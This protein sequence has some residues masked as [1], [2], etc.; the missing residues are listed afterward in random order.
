MASRYTTEIGTPVT[1]DLK[2]LA[3][4]GIKIS[5]QL[6]EEITDK[7]SYGDVDD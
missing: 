4:Q 1:I 6:G 5:R 2:A 7:P 3:P